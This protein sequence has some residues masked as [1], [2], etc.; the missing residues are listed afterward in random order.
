LNEPWAIIFAALIGFAAYA[1]FTSSDRNQP[2][3]I[4]S[5]PTINVTSIPLPTESESSSAASNVD[6]NTETQHIWIERSADTIAIC[7]AQAA[8]LSALTVEAGENEQPRLLG[9][10]FSASATTQAGQ[11]WCLQQDDADFATP[12]SCTSENTSIQ[13]QVSDWR[14]S[15]VTLSLGG[16]SLGSCEAQPDS[17]TAYRCDF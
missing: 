5:V 6:Q 9:E 2:S 1:L 4:T 10:I 16:T 8:D 17:L 7:S 11:C 15:S 13:A 3:G 12:D 14:N